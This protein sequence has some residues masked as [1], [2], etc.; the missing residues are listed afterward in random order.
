MINNYNVYR[1]LI[2]GKK[3]RRYIALPVIFQDPYTY[4]LK[5]VFLS[6]Y[7]IGNI[8][9]VYLYLGNGG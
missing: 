4:R 5:D 1:I 8:Y 7:S 3:Y 6:A 2:A 9:K